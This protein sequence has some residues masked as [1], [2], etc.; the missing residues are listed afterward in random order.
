VVCN[1]TPREWRADF[2]CV[3]FIDK[4]NSPIGTRASYV[5]ENGRPLLNRV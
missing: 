2:R 4:P 5:V 1:V 3:D